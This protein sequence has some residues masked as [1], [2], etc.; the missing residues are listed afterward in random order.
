[1]NNDKQH[2]QTNNA[3]MME[4]KGGFIYSQEFQ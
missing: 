1:M 4:T 3:K 2:L